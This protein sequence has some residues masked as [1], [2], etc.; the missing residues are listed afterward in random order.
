MWLNFIE[1]R[2][3]DANVG[4]DEANHYVIRTGLIRGWEL[5]TLDLLGAHTVGYY[6]D[7]QSIWGMAMYHTN[8]TREKRLHCSRD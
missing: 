6:L 5:S 4:S 3:C 2:G 8:S 7:E 1:E